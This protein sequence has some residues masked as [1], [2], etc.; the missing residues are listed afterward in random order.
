MTS[1]PA[2][3][4]SALER[5]RLLQIARRSVAVTIGAASVPVAEPEADATALRQHAGAFVTLRLD[6]ALR[7]CIGHVEAD[8]PLVGVV[9]GVAVAAATEDPRFGPVTVDELPGVI[10]EVSVLGPLVEYADP[11]RIEVGR[12]GLVVDDGARRGLL[13][14]QVA[15]EWRWDAR[16]FLAQTCQKAGL[17]PDAWRTGARVF[18]FEAEVFGEDD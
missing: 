13:L 5:R 12:H 8:R 17:R 14:P 2:V 4:L 6:R 18:A 11:T 16:T 1:G 15:V 7:G 9:R 10:F 3:G